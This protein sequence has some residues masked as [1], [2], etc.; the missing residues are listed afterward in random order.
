MFANRNSLLRV[1]GHI[2]GTNLGQIGRQIL[3][4]SENTIVSIYAYNM[5]HKLL[6]L[7]DLGKALQG[8]VAVP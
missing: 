3:G 7:V 4:R 1:L 6:D 8:T 5:N 2:S